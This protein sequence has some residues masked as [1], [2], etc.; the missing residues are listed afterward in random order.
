M[1]HD[2][3]GSLEE[4]LVIK[5][6]ILETIE[7]SDGFSTNVELLPVMLNEAFFL[8]RTLIENDFSL[9][10]LISYVTLMQCNRF[11][12]YNRKGISEPRLRHL[13]SIGF[14]GHITRVDRGRSDQINADTI[15]RAAKREVFEETKI[16]LASH[17]EPVGFINE[18]V[19][20]VGK[21][22]FGIFYLIEF[23]ERIPFTSTVESGIFKME[24][25]E[26]LRNA[27]NLE[28]WSQI[29]VK[30]FDLIIRG[31]D[32]KRTAWTNYKG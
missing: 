10:Q 11:L 6:N 7:L 25:L 23:D 8:K 13:S 4:V 12:V 28:P 20:A 9:K 19:T 16:S 3:K 17:D 26:E 27:K 18:D 30:N 24:S 29:L 31:H 22:H 14:G 15:W 1:L 5:K 21:V 2:R 32:L